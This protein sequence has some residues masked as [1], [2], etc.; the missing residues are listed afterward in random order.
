MDVALV[1]TL[2]LISKNSPKWF[3]LKWNDFWGFKFIE[4]QVSIFIF[5]VLKNGQNYKKKDWK[6][7]VS[8]LL[9]G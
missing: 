4:K 9:N 7:V 1:T 3:F 8:Y 6:F 2:F 5:L